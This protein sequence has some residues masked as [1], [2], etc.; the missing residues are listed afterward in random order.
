MNCSIKVLIPFHLHV[1]DDDEVEHAEFGMG[2]EEPIER[3][4]FRTERHPFHR[5]LHPVQTAAPSSAPVEQTEQ[6]SQNFRHVVSPPEARRDPEDRRGPSYSSAEAVFCSEDG[7]EAHFVLPQRREFSNRLQS[8][9]LF[10]G[11][12]FVKFS[13]KEVPVGWCNSPTCA[14][15]STDP[16]SLRRAT[17]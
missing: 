5:L 15:H 7:A 4:S 3:K 10:I 14:Q 12:R 2:V 8:K 9:F 17:L 6:A 11:L 13:D 1:D 16:D